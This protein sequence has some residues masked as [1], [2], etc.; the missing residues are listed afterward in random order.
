MWTY[1]FPLRVTMGRTL[2]QT[3]RAAHLGSGGSIFRHP[4]S[5]DTLVQPA[6]S[7]QTYSRPSSGTGDR[8]GGTDGRR[9]GVGPRDAAQRARCVIWAALGFAFP[10]TAPALLL[11]RLCE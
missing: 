7:A 4:H 8:D 2:P 1:G 6:V 9:D 10:L 3:L 5:R 11:Q